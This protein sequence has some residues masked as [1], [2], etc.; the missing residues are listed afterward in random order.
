VKSVTDD[1]EQTM[2]LLDF[3]TRGAAAQI[4]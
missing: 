1:N 2:E 4:Q 3:G